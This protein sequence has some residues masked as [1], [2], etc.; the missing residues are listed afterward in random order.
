[1]YHLN[2][3]KGTFLKLK[4]CPKFFMA[5][6]QLSQLIISLAT[7]LV[8]SNNQQQ[9]FTAVVNV[10]LHLKRQ[11]FRLEIISVMCML[12]IVQNCSE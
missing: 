7:V 9:H 10:R 8:V 12:H 1:M 2:R 6:L 4:V 5:Q 3:N 11:E